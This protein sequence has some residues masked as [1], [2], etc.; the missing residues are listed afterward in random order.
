LPLLCQAVSLYS[1]SPEE[2]TYQKELMEDNQ[3]R[4]ERAIENLLSE[5]SKQDAQ[6]ISEYLFQS[7]EKISLSTL[8]KKYQMPKR[9]VHH[10]IE[11][12]K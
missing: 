12:L 10:K 2:V 1:E 7:Q 3:N 6:I 5:L 4:H 8:E 11:L 9:T